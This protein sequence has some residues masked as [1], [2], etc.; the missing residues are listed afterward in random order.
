MTKV[1]DHHGEIIVALGREGGEDA[2]VNAIPHTAAMAAKLKTEQ[3][4]A[5]CRRRKAIAEAPNG[6]IRP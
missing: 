6:W 4:E 1:A 5:A 2:K 3:G